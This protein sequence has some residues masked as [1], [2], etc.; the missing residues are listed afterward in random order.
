MDEAL[1][2]DMQKHP[3]KI[4]N[5]YFKEVIF[6]QILIAFNGPFDEV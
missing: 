5:I 6:A 4:T 2:E 1:L 3:R